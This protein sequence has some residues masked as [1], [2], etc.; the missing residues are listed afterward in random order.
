VQL[1]PIDI[2]HTTFNSSFRGYR[3]SEVD[4]FLRAALETVETLVKE[5]VELERKAEA[6]GQEAERLRSVE[7]T[8]SSAL[9]LA[10][11]GA[12]EIRANAHKEAK[13]ILTEAEQARV[14]MTIESQSELEKCRAD[15]GLLREERARFEAEFRRMLLDYVDWIDSHKPVAASEAA[16]VSSPSQT[17]EPPVAMPLEA[18]DESV[19]TPVEEPPVESVPAQDAPS[20]DYSSFAPPTQEPQAGDAQS[21]APQASAA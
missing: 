12:D 19:E 14:R 1:T 18:P 9:V 16:A 13:L 8:M 21:T 3:K 4:A 17:E 5:K 7:S 11:Q 6:F 15:I 2:H 20:V 10:Q